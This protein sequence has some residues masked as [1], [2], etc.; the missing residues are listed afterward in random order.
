[1]CPTSTVILADFLYLM[2]FTQLAIH[3]FGYNEQKLKYEKKYKRY[4]NKTWL[5]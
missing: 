1:M 3:Y 4:I 5:Q 2:F